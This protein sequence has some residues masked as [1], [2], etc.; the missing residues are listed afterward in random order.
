MRQALLGS[1]S[2]PFPGNE[3]SELVDSRGTDARARRERFDRDGYLFVRGLL[4]RELVLGARRR[5][6][7][8]FETDGSI[9]ELRRWARN[10]RSI[11]D[12]VEHPQ[13]FALA[14]TILGSETMTYAFKWMRVVAERA[15]TGAHCDV[16]YMGRGS[17]NV[18][19]VWI[20]F[21]DVAVEQG[22]LAVCERSHR[23]E[24]FQ[25]IHDTYGRLDV[26][27]DR[28]A[29]TGWL[30]D[31]PLELD[32]VWRSADFEAGDVILFGMHTLHAATANQTGELRVSCDVRFQP[33]SEPADERWVGEDPIGHT[34]FGVGGPGS[35]TVR[36]LRTEW[37]L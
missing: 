18:R 21:G 3:L 31:E 35:T 9:P 27:R 5:A 2:V 25:R 13:L 29:G 16:V 10:D 37:N 32:G 8:Q 4:P 36:A 23:L 1:K 26:D 14:E 30:T 34:A 20:P 33:A 11:L 7:E 12:V 17:R 19:T 15:G 22:T 6:L 28:I 24:A